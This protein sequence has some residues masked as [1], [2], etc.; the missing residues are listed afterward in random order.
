MCIVSG[1]L[2]EIVSLKLSRNNGVIVVVGINGRKPFEGIFLRMIL[3]EN[4]WVL[5]SFQGGNKCLIRVLRVGGKLELS[6]Q[7]GVAVEI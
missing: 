4:E 5:I 1:N 2:Q 6:C 7:F 3:G